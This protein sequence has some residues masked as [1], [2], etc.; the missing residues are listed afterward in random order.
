[1][2][3]N[4]HVHCFQWMNVWM[5]HVPTMGP[6]LTMDQDIIVPVLLAISARTVHLVHS[7]YYETISYILKFLFRKFHPRHTVCYTIKYHIVEDFCFW[8]MYT[9][10]KHIYLITQQV[11]TYSICIWKT[12]PYRYS[13]IIL[14]CQ[15]LPI[16]ISC[17]YTHNT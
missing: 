3:E 15:C 8:I 6:A 11:Q 9:W 4:F 1:M 16:Y 13:T 2:F 14:W 10:L 5:H 12:L 17:Y 7:F